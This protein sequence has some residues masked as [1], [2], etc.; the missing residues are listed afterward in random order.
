M[1][2]RLP[3]EIDEQVAAVVSRYQGQGV[4]GFHDLRTRRSGSLKFIDLHLDVERRLTFEQAHA[5]SVRVLREI[6]AAI[7]RSRVSIHTDPAD[8]EEARK[9][10]AGGRRQADVAKDQ[11]QQNA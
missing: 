8:E 1:D 7:P 5:I 4:F 11:H 6:E 2:R 3:Q 10:E 9:Q